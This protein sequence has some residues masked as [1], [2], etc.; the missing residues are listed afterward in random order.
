M[1]S[2]DIFLSIVAL[3]YN[4][5]A[6]I[7]SFTTGKKSYRKN[8]LPGEIVIT[9]DGSTDRTGELLKGSKKE[10]PNHKTINF[11]KNSGYGRA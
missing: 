9:N 4:E 7:E 8:N 5:K 10:Y 1:S 11:K 2:K 6:Y 3:T